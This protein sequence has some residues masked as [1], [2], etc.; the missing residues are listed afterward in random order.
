M[1]A[2]TFGSCQRH[3]ISL[4]VSGSRQHDLWQVVYFLTEMV[5][6]AVGSPCLCD[7]ICLTVVEAVRKPRDQP[8]CME[9][10]EG[11]IGKS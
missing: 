6:G 10:V 11:G 2:E 4:E 5:L 7:D 1:R 3:R 8:V 9:E